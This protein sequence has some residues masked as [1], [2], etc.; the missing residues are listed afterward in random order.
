MEAHTDWE[1]G[2]PELL[3]P[4][5]RIWLCVHFRGFGMI[6]S[7]SAEY[8]AKFKLLTGEQIPCQHLF[9]V[10]QDRT[11]PLSQQS[12]GVCIDEKE[13]RDTPSPAGTQLPVV[14][15]NDW[16]NHRCPAANLD[17]F[18]LQDPSILDQG[19]DKTLLEVE[20]T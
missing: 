8:E 17:C 14:P 12:Q 20:I 7:N 11:L 4:P 15:V 18:Q 6:P 1:A 16:A 5:T 19:W 3:L 2:L 10:N 13:S 9:L